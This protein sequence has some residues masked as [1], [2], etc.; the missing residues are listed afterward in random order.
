MAQLDQ[1]SVTL[2]ECSAVGVPQQAGHY[3]LYPQLVSP[4]GAVKLQ[5]GDLI[6][7]RRRMYRVL[8]L[9]K[10]KTQ[11]T[12]VL[13]VADGQYDTKPKLLSLESCN[14][15]QAEPAD[16]TS[17]TK[18][19]GEWIGAQK[20]P[21]KVIKAPTT[22]YTREKRQVNK[23]L[24][25][26]ECSKAHPKEKRVR[27]A[28]TTLKSNKRTKTICEEAQPQSLLQPKPKSS[29]C[30]QITTSASTAR[31]E[32]T[33]P[34]LESQLYQ[35]PADIPL[36]LRLRINKQELQALRYDLIK[37]E[38]RSN[39]ERDR[40][41]LRSNQERDRI[42]RQIYEERLH[43]LQNEQLLISALAH[44]SGTSLPNQ[45]F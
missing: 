32:V 43:E 36:A 33:E 42:E 29:N 2:S 34:Q 20:V 6:S 11:H 15:L 37:S 1:E 13:A 7:F 22:V 5:I 27:K 30:T 10:D 18:C 26:D 25:F 40:I 23:P 38:L 8:S 24:P 17:I 45:Y 12:K 44:T 19:L 3:E 28:I 16:E 14:V 4:G 31:H 39:Q 21:P 41:E 35:C 9:A